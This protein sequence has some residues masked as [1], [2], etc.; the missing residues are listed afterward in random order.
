[1]ILLIS[2]WLLNGHFIF[3]NSKDDFIK[4]F[5]LKQC[6]GLTG[7]RTALTNKTVP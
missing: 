3:H 5:L 7:V 4:Y 1:M 2:V 6:T